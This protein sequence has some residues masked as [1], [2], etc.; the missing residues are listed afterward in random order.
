MVE[1]SLTSRP[2]AV[3]PRI[4]DLSRKDSSSCAVMNPSRKVSRRTTAHAPTMAVLS[5]YRLLCQRKR[6]RSISFSVVRALLV[7]RFKAD[8]AGARHK[9]GSTS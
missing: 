5:R 7:D 3:L 8:S 1:Y 2:F 6:V 4:A 9:P